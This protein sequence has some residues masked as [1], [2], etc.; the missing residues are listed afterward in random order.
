RPYAEVRCCVAGGGHDCHGG[1]QSMNNCIFGVVGAGDVKHS[2]CKKRQA[3]HDNGIEYCFRVLDVLRQAG[4]AECCKVQRKVD[5]SK[6]HKK[7][8]DHIDSSAVKMTQT[9]VMGGEAANGNSGKTVA[10]GIKQ[11]HTGQPVGQR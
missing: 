1:E 6:K 7:Y 3:K 10:D 8:S 9:V 5:A 4:L 11:T 2:H